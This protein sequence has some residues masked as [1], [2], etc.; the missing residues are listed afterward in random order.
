MNM[1]L[2]IKKIEEVETK[3][4]ESNIITTITANNGNLSKFR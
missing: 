3:I 1:T 4:Y 2:F